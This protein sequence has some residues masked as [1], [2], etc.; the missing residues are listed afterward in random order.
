M[1]YILALDQGTTSSRAI[2]FDHDGRDRGDRPAGVPADLPAARLGRARPAGDLGVADR[3]RGRGA[4]PGAAAAA[5]RRRHRHHQPARDHDRLGSR[6]RASR[7][8]TPSSGRTA[9]P[10]AFCDRLRADGAETAGPRADRPGPRCLLLRHARSRW[11]L[12]NVPGRAGARRGRRARLRHRRHLARLEADRRTRPRHRRQQRLAHDAL[13]HPHRRVGRRAAAPLRRPASDAARGAVARA[14]STARS[15]TTL[16]LGGRADRRHR[17]RPAG[18]PLRPDVRRARAGEEHLRH[19]LLHAAEHRARS[20]CASRHQL[21]TT[22]AWKH[23]RRHG[24]RARRQRLHRRRGR[25]VAARRP[26]AHPHRRPRSR[27]WPPRVAGQRRRLPRAGLRRARARRTGIRTPA[28][29]IVGLTRGTTAGHIA[30][31]ALESIAFQVGR[32]ARRHAGG[33][34]ASARRSCAWTAARRATTC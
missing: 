22:V 31:A 7:S 19:R 14:R 1:P 17:R 34:P 21:L 11:I 23:R 25:A 30:R 33:L 24:V 27:R 2:L 18:G 5:R 16:G 8:A 12:D 15:S 10:P 28:A 20:R 13:Q 3:R 9:A 6:D 4:R 32:P 26:R 29:L